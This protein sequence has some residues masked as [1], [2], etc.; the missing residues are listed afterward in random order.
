VVAHLNPA[1]PGFESAAAWLIATGRANSVKI[2]T[3][4]TK[5]GRIR[6]VDEVQESERTIRL[7]PNL[8]S[9]LNLGLQT[10]N[11]VERMAL[12]MSDKSGARISWNTTI[13]EMCTPGGTLALLL[14]RETHAHIAFQADI[15]RGRLANA[16]EEIAVFPRTRDIRPDQYGHSHLPAGIRRCWRKHLYQNGAL[17]ASFADGEAMGVHLSNSAQ[18]IGLDCREFEG[19]PAHWHVEKWTIIYGSGKAPKPYA[20]AGLTPKQLQ[21]LVRANLLRLLRRNQ[22]DEDR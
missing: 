4:R 11:L 22:G 12:G 20:D 6:L 5:V 17:V 1:T 15:L 19:F 18:S 10:H 16:R 21:D 3:H 14:P 9:L 8:P 13:R 7:N 2:T